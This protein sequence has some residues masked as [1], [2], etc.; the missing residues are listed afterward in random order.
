MNDSH[1]YDMIERKK[2]RKKDLPIETIGKSKYTTSY[3]IY[4]LKQIQKVPFFA[5]TFFYL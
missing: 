5:T 4:T 1:L 2:E 3:S